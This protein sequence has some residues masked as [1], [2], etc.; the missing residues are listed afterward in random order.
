ML[1]TL[2]TRLN[3]SGTVP[4][5]GPVASI[6]ADLFISDATNNSIEIYNGLDGTVVG[7]GV[8]SGAGGLADPRAF[9]FGPDGNLYVASGGTNSILRFNGATGAF[10]DVFDTLGSSPATAIEFGP[11]GFLYVAQTDGSNSLISR[12]DAFTPGTFVDIFASVGSAPFDMEFGP[13]GNLYV[14][15]EVGSDQVIRRLG[16]GGAE[17]GGVG[18]GSVLATIPNSAAVGIAIDPAGNL[19]VGDDSNGSIKRFTSEGV[20]IDEFVA[21][22]TGG[23]SL[24]EDID[25]GADGHLYAISSSNGGEVLEFSEVDGSFIGTLVANGS[26]GLGGPSFLLFAPGF[27]QPAQDAEFV[28]IDIVWRD[29]VAVNVGTLGNDEVR[30]IAPNGSIVSG[31][32]QSVDNGTNGTPRVAT[33]RVAAPGGF[34]GAEDNGFYRVES[35]GGG[36]DDTSA[37][38]SD[39]RVLGRLLVNLEHQTPT[40]DQ[41]GS[42]VTVVGTDG[43]DLFSSFG[44]SSSIAVTVVTPQTGSIFT[45]N[46]VGGISADFITGAG[47]DVITIDFGVAIHTYKVDAGVSSTS[48]LDQL[49][50]VTGATGNTTTTLS[51]NSISGAFGSVET[52]GVEHFTLSIQGGPNHNVF[53]QSNFVGGTSTVTVTSTNGA[54]NSL[55]IFGDNT[56]VSLLVTSSEIKVE[57]QSTVELE[58]NQVLTDGVGG[59]NGLNFSQGIAQ[60]PDGRHVYVTSIIDQSVAL[61]DRDTNTGD[62]TFVAT[63]DNNSGG[64]T[65]MTSPLT[66]AVSPDGKHVYVGSQGTNALIVFDRNEVNGSLS[67]V[68]T[69]VDGTEGISGMD[70]LQHV[71]ISPDGKH[72]YVSGAASNSVAV[73]LR[74]AVSGKLSFVQAVTD[75]VNG[76]D[77]LQ[78]VVRTI[79]SNDGRNLY[80]AANGEGAVGVFARDPATGKLSFVQVLTDGGTGGNFLANVNALALDPTGSHLIAGAFVDSAI[81]VFARDA[82]TGQLTF[83]Q[84]LSEGVGGVNGITGVNDVVVS[85]DG[86]R[87]YVVGHQADSVVT[88][89]RDTGSGVLAQVDRAADGVNGFQGLD[90]VRAAIVSPDGKQVYTISFT[91]ASLVGMQT[92][93]ELAVNHSTLAAL[94]VGTGFGDD[95][96]MVLTDGLTTNVALDLGAGNDQVQINDT[97]GAD[98]VLVAGPTID[99]NGRVIAP[100]QVEIVNLGMF[101]DGADQVTI[102]LPQTAA[103]QEIQVNGSANGTDSLTINGPTAAQS[104]DLTSGGVFVGEVNAQELLFIEAEFDSVSMNAPQSVATSP[105][106]HHVYVAGADSDTIA[107]FERDT[108]SGE[109]TFLSFIQ[110]E[111]GGVT[112]L[113]GVS[114]VAVSPDGQRVYT[115]SR[116]ESKISVFDRDSGSGALTQVQIVQDGVGGVDGLQGVNQ[117]EVSPDGEFLVAT[118]RSENKIALFT[119]EANGQLTFRQGVPII[120][121]RGA[122]YSG[123]GRF[124]YVTSVENDSIVVFEQLAGGT[125]TQVQSIPNSGS[126][127]NSL[128]DPFD[129]VVSPD[130]NNVYVASDQSDSVTVFNRNQSDGTL[131]FVEAHIEGVGATTGINSASALEISPDGRKVFVAGTFSS[132]V[133]TFDRSPSGTLTFG[134][135]K[136]DEVNGVDGLGGSRFLA[137]SSDGRQLYAVGEFEDA[138]A[139][140]SLGDQVPI[141]HAGMEN[142]LVQAGDGD[143]DIFLDNSTEGGNVSVTVLGGEGNDDILVGGEGGPLILN[144]Q[145]GNDKLGSGSAG[146]LL[147]GEAGDDIFLSSAANNTMD[148]GADDDTY[149]FLDGFGEHTIIDSGG[150]DTFTFNAGI[151]TTTPLV[152][153]IDA[154]SLTI[155]SN[156]STITA[157]NVIEKIVGGTDDDQFFFVDQAVLAGGAGIIDGGPGT[158]DFL[159]Y[160]A[161]T[162]AV[163]VDLIGGIATGLS[164]VVNVEN[165]VGAGATPQL[166]GPTPYLSFADSPFTGT[167]FQYFHLED[168]TDGLLNTPGVTAN[169][170]TVFTTANFFTDSVDGD[171]G[172]VD[173]SGSREGSF[174]V[175]AGAVTLVFT[176]DEGVL[177]SLPTHAGLVWTDGL[178]NPTR[179]RAF[180]ISNNLLVDSGDLNLPNSGMVQDVTSEDVFFGVTFAGGIKRIEISETNSIEIDHLQYGLEQI[181]DT[182]VVTN[183]ND[184]GAGSLRDAITAANSASNRARIAFN[185]PDTD[186]NFIDVDSGLSGGDAGAD[187]F[188]IPLLSP[189]PALN[190]PLGIIID[191]ETQDAFTPTFNSAF[192]PSIIL[193]GT[194]AGGNEGGHGLVLSG[195]SNEIIGLTIGGFDAS[196]IVIG[197]S[198]DNNLIVASHIGVNASGTAAFANDI[199]ITV[200]G[201]NNQIGLPGGAFSNTII[202]GNNL[203]GIAISGVTATG[204]RVQNVQIGINDLVGPIDLGNVSAGIRIDNAPGNTIGGA[205]ADE[206]NVISFNGG[207][208]VA[209]QGTFSTGNI[210]RGNLIGTT[211]DGS[212]AAP[213]FV[214]VS[215][216]LGANGNQIGGTLLGEGNAIAFNTAQ[217]VRLAD[218]GTD[219]N[220]IRGVNSIFQNGALGIDIDGDGVTNND[221]GDTDNGPNQQTN[222]PVISVVNRLTGTSE[223]HVEGTIS[224]QPNTQFAIDFYADTSP[225]PSGHGEGELFLGT[226]LVTADGS[227]NAFF[228]LDLPVLAP[229]GSLV[230]ATATDDSDNTSEFS[231]A[232]AATGASTFIVTNT[233]DSGPG[234]LRQAIIDANAASGSAL[235][236]FNIP[237]TDPNFI[238]VDS[239]V[240]G[241]DPDEDAFR[242]SL[243]SALPA[244]INPLGTIIDGESQESFNAP[245]FDSNLGPAIIIDGASVGVGD[246]LALTSSNN[247]V[248]GLA[249][250]NFSGGNGIFVTGN[251]NLIVASHLGV[252]AAGSAAAGN[253]RGITISGSNNQIGMAGGGFAP[254]IIGG[255]DFDGM[256]FVSGGADNNRVQNV[257]IGINE[258]GGTAIDLGN[259]A[260]AAGI[261]ID[262]GT[263]NLIGGGGPGEGNVIAFNSEG[264]V[265][266]DESGTVVKGNLIGTDLSGNN[267]A[268]NASNG[269]SI[270][271]GANLSQIGGTAAGEGNRI[272]FNGGAGVVV[273]DVSG[274]GNAIRGNEIFENGGLGIDLNGDGVT[275]NDAGDADNG[276]NQQTNFPVIT[277]VE[278]GATTRVEGSLSSLALTTFFID[279]FLNDSP[280]PSGNGEGQTFIG[281]FPLTT[282]ASGAATFNETLAVSS[283]P[284]QFITLTATDTAGNTSEFSQAVAA[285]GAT[286]FIVTNTNDSGAGSLRQAILDANAASGAATIEFN[287]PNTDPNFIDSDVAI[288]GGDAAADVYRITLS[289]TLPSLTNPD[290]ITIGGESQSVFGGD[291]NALG[292]E[293]VLNGAVAVADGLVLSSDGNQVSGL[294]LENFTVDFLR[295]VGGNNNAIFGNYIG[296]DA[297]G[298]LGRAGV[299]FDATTGV[300]ISGNSNILDGNIISALRVGIAIAGTSSDNQIFGNFIGT[301][302][303][304]N[305]DLG[306][307]TNG[308]VVGG[309]TNNTIGQPGNG[310]VI[311]GNDNN[312]ISINGGSTT[313][314]VVQANIIGLSADLTT[315]LG[316]NGI[317]IALSDASLTR[318]GGSIPSEGNFIAHNG[319]NGVQVGLGTGNTIRNNQIFNNT[320]L[321]IDLID[322]SIFGVNPNDVGD[323]DTGS[324]NLQNFPVIT[325]VESG[326]VRIVGT[327]N[328]TPN[329]TFDIDF[330][331]NQ[332]ADAS[333]FG[334]GAIVID[335]TQVTTDGT[336]NASFDVSF[337]AG[338]VPGE[339]ITATATNTTTGDTS[340]FSQAVAAAAATTFI[341]TNTNNSG[342]GSLRQAITDANAASGAARI[343][344]NIPNTDPNFI[345]TDGAI[346]GGDAGLDAFRITVTTALPNLTNPDG[347]SI[348]GGTQLDFG[349]DTNALGPEIILS[350]GGTVNEGI[351]LASSGNEV[352]E[353]VFEN[354]TS[355]YIRI[356]NQ[357][358]NIIAGN[359]IGTD[360]SGTLDRGGASSTGVSVFGSNNTVGGAGVADRNIISGLNRGVQIGGTGS[361]NQ[362]LGN[363]IGTDRTGNFD[364]G[365][366]LEGVLVN[367]GTNAIIGAPGAGNVI[368]GNGGFGILLLNTGTN[369]TMIQ[370]NTIGADVTGANALANNSDGINVGDCDNTIIGGSDATLGNTI[371]FNG[372]NGVNVSNGNASG[373]TIRSNQIFSNSARGIDLGSNGVTINDAGDADSGANGF[374]NFP[375]ISLVEAGAVRIVG[376]LNSTPNS[377]FEVDFYSNTS[378]DPSGFGEG[379]IVIGSHQVT[380]DGSGNASFD[381]N[382]AAGIAAGNFVTA[383]ATNVTTG[384]T[385]EFSQAVVATLPGLVY[386]GPAPY[387][388][389]SDSP[390]SGLPFSSFFLENFEDG[391]LNTPG[392]SANIGSVFNSGAF[393]DGVDGDDGAV[394]GTSLTGRSFGVSSGGVTIDFSFNSAALGGFPTHAGLVWTDGQ[395]SPV[396]FEAFDA[397]GN[398]LGVSGPFTL[399]ISGVQGNTAE[400]RFFGVEFAGGISKIRI[401]DLGGAGLEVDHVQYGIAGAANTFV[402]TNTDDSGAGSLR[403]A[404]IAANAASGSS[405][406]TFSIPTSDPNFIDTDSA[407][408]G[409]DAAA[410]VWVINLLSALP[411][412][413]ANDIF[414]NGVTQEAFGGDT[415]ALGP[416][417]V[418]DGLLAGAD[419]AGLTILS[420]NNR[421]VGLNIQ[422][423]DGDAIII[424]DSDNNELGDNYIGT[425][426]T[427]TLARPNRVGVTVQSFTSAVN[428]RV[429]LSGQGNLISGNT[430]FGVRLA[431]SGAGGNFIT[432]NF[433]GTDR[434]GAAALGNAGA[435]VEIILGAHDN[436][437][438]SGQFN[439]RNVISGNAAAGVLIL[440]PGT[441]GNIVEGNFIGVNAAG[442]AAL[443]NGAS[444]VEIFGTDGNIIGQGGVGPGNV[445]SGNLGHGI[446]LD[447]ADNNSID[448]NNIGT[449]NNGVAG[450]GNALSGVSLNNGSDNNRIG[451]N[452]PQGGNVIAGNGQDGIAIFGSNN[453][454]V[455]HN[456]IGLLEGGLADGNGGD[457]VRIFGT[458]Q[459]NVIG[460]PAI[461]FADAAG[462][463]SNVS[464]P[465]SGEAG[466]QWLF[467]SAATLGGAITT[468]TSAFVTESVNG[469]SRAG[470][471]FTSGPFVGRNATGVTQTPAT[472]SVGAGQFVMAPGAT[473]DAVA[474]LT[475]PDEDIYQIRG[476]FKNGN[477]TG[478]PTVDVHILVN[479]VSVFDGFLN[480]SGFGSEVQSPTLLIDLESGDTVT[481]VVGDGNNGSTSDAVIVD[482]KVSRASG[483]LL[484]GNLGSGVA[485]SGA[486][487]SNNKVQGNLIGVDESGTLSRGNQGAAGVLIDT[488]ATNNLIGGDDLDGFGVG[489]IISGNSGAGVRMAN[490]QTSGNRVEGNIIGATMFGNTGLPNDGGGVVITSFATGN[491]VGGGSPGAGNL[492]SGNAL[493]GVEISISAAN[494]R[495]QGNRIG[496]DFQGLAALGN[497]ERG[498]FINNADGNFVGT[499]GDGSGDAT[500]GNI[501]SGNGFEGVG[502]SG[503]SATGN[504]IAGNF[505]GTNKSGA[506]AIGNS[507]RGVAIFAGA[508]NNRVGTDGNGVSD[509]NERN[510]ISGNAFEGVIIDQ[511][512]TDN[513]IIAGNFIGTDVTGLIDLG[514]LGSGVFIDLAG[515]TVIG[516]ALAS[517]RNVISGNQVHGIHVSDANATIILGNL[518]GTNLSG[519]A[520]LG[521][522]IN[523]VFVDGGAT[524]T[525]IGDG[526]VGGRNIISGNTVRGVQIDGS[527]TDIS[528]IRGNFIGTNITGTAALGN[529][530]N[531]VLLSSGATNIFVG[532]SSAG[533]GN[534]ISGNALVGVQI[535]GAS[536]ISIEGN[537]IGL[538]AAGTAALGNGESGVLI[539]QG[540]FDNAV[541]NGAASGRNIISG[542]ALVGVQIADV[543]TTNNVVDGNFIGTNAAGTADLGNGQV[544][545][546][547]NFGAT[548]NRI[549]ELDGNVI[550]G[551][552]LIGIQISDGGTGGNTVKA[553]IIGLNASGDADITDA[554]IGIDIGNGASNNTIGGPNAGD[555]NVISGHAFH[556]VRVIGATSGG[557]VIEGN[558]IGTDINGTAD[559][560][561]LFDGVQ[562]QNGPNNVVRGNL[563]SGNNGDGVDLGPGTGSVVQGNLIGTDITGNLDLGNGEAGVRLVGSIGAAIGGANAVDRNIISGNNIAGVMIQDNAT[564]NSVRGNFIGTNQAGTGALGNTFD[565]VQIFNGANGNTIGGLSVGEGNVISGN[566]QD[567]VEINGAGADGNIVQGNIIGLNALGTVALGNGQDGIRLT[568]VDTNN[569]SR[570]TISANGRD[571][572]LIDGGSTG[573]VLSGNFIGTD[574]SAAL[575]RGN[576]R[577]GVRIENSPTNT[578]GGNTAGNPGTGNGNVISGNGNAGI[579]IKGAT[580]TG[581][582]I[583]GNVIGANVTGTVAIP[584]AADGIYIAGASGNSIGGPGNGNLI[585]GN[586]GNGINIGGAASTNNVVQ[587][588]LIGTNLAGNAA[589]GNSTNG[590]FV[591]DDGARA[592]D[593]VSGYASGNFIGG[594]S[595]SSRNIL[596]GNGTFGYTTNSAGLAGTGN[597]IHGNFIGTDASGT[598]DVPNGLGGVLL[599]GQNNRL[600][601]ANP[602]EG[603]LI[604]GNDGPGV[605]LATTAANGNQIFGNLIGTALNGVDALPNIGEGVL[606]HAIGTAAINNAVGG[607]LA[608]QGNTIAFNQGP[609]VG[610][611]G[612]ATRIA[613]RGNSIFSNMGLG[614]DLELNGVTNNDLDDPDAGSNN[615]QNFPTLAAAI[616]GSTIV[617]GS[618][619]A[620]PSTVHQ[621]DFYSNNSSESGLRQGRVFIGSA[622]VTTN[623]GGDADFIVT[624]PVTTAAGDFITVTATDAN[625][626]T[627]EFSADVAVSQDTTAPTATLTTAPAVTIAGGTTYTFT[628]TYADEAALLN[629]TIGANDV[630]VHGP[631]SFG[632]VATLVS[633]STTANAASIVATYRITAPGGTFNSAD[634]GTYDI[635]AFPGAVTDLA[636]N[637]TV[638]GTLGQFTVAIGI[639]TGNASTPNVSAGGETTYR[640]TVTYADPDG[641]DPATFDGGDVIVNGPLGFTTGVTFIGADRLTRGTPRTATYEFTAPGGFL[642]AADNGGYQVVIQPNQ[643][644]D[645]R[646]AFVP[647]STAGNFTIN[648]DSSKPLVSQINIAS[649]RNQIAALTFSV[650]YADDVSINI[651]TLDDLDIRIAGP[652]GFNRRATLIGVSGS[653]GSVVASYAISPASGPFTHLNNGSYQVF[654]ESN[655]VADDSGNVAVGKLL[656]NFRVKISSRTPT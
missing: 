146:D 357:D 91:D 542:N 401:R 355:N 650:T 361:G 426:A 6:L 451:E 447:N 645:G 423:F 587:G 310:N 480:L 3:F 164:S 107:I 45:K 367:G 76:A 302:R 638:G 131:T 174:G 320:Q 167:P 181:V 110:D 18:L 215:L 77:G 42:Q 457:G 59:V 470:G 541:G 217:G 231:L 232:V 646:G 252:N 580:A 104:Y 589:L 500:E 125:L 13:D 538:N 137:M 629:S 143:D 563:I 268:G 134:E 496:T 195:A 190:N 266:N 317:G 23:L 497:D 44:N 234:S 239:A 176:F 157:D 84:A 529:G 78:D 64:I 452:V 409:G 261:R 21:G 382:L 634:N 328:S 540:A 555:R 153:T 369:G 590:I 373:V 314:T 158:G 436:F 118:G 172:A 635:I 588:N 503:S 648:I 163:S 371:A 614:I 439:D 534:V 289:S 396:S 102:N 51:N 230:S 444:G 461:D 462:D 612:N 235:I 491:F 637:G 222:F 308:V 293:I 65:N 553:N 75:G 295:I 193:D 100:V 613:I 533:Q 374:Q 594:A 556:G 492:I 419:T 343:E 68:A 625:G 360:A 115:A 300:R 177:G 370:S 655:Q 224:G 182:F 50:V 475:V 584:N 272:A 216:F 138:V 627:S 109:L 60:S 488:E 575:D 386:L 345:N 552:N 283:S 333:G 422:R 477:A 24:P 304:G 95:L 47:A 363:F 593:P 521:N 281:S 532:G 113:D 531:G 430:G 473:G 433:I 390:F 276:P 80:T 416:E 260:G 415:N 178:S 291:T 483:N 509:V 168:F 445:I 89:S 486:G 250:T 631:N 458:S 129:V 316:N 598:T 16:P 561:N 147:I 618:L 303:T 528:S 8:A 2:E 391:L 49:T 287:I 384:N 472:L 52:I 171:D 282:N 550:S 274:D 490:S 53:S 622:Q 387:L 348:I 400:D 326:A 43:T 169:T 299:G 626:N 332:T 307:R 427:G 124:L 353:L 632:A 218:A 640:F 562:I 623:A 591:G 487:T 74:D 372:G 358:S 255:N 495:V 202:G 414:I 213:N 421:I 514:N 460:G 595:V 186:A 285:A 607:V 99:F 352:R 342:A 434:T 455:N 192:G 346:A 96:A 321:G 150:F 311:S 323:A 411:A 161:Y 208:G 48:D 210:V 468:F 254:T 549:G 128:D 185:I 647:S 29:D 187:A 265:I 412:I 459:G 569:I 440:D 62:L 233:S 324:N 489:N 341:V 120:G 617:T 405:E 198:S 406:I 257:R 313:G 339:F 441:T 582:S 101:G 536:A 20:F 656:T 151:P 133:V 621:L 443:G 88:F 25:F 484:S 336:G 140:F 359:Y 539:N 73:F 227:G 35:L 136:I 259:G 572:V 603:N 9:A 469:W 206:G 160:T 152:V 507:G 188:R 238:D 56:P 643:V 513:N 393:Q 301:D 644:S 570:N 162:T 379:Q 564:N 437:I 604:S 22:G 381:V 600:G 565:G 394:D 72:L 180:D 413:T 154:A 229:A 36:V 262:G 57:S 335:S 253:D 298:T 273:L 132:A 67:F 223:T 454:T 442:A 606:A 522:S 385:S 264:I 476:V 98:T 194:S 543:G 205:G 577:N 4:A 605:T 228:N 290:G 81:T 103:S 271:Q 263:G 619:N 586:I 526:T 417:I 516:G 61:F 111:N 377:T 189:L 212:A 456:R 82:G 438:G 165:V 537:I 179:F 418:I 1:E 173:G 312:G 225:D 97:N 399:T 148:G 464:N 14:T 130:G 166:L 395:G 630:E 567:G 523:G 505:I 609:G 633:K 116:F 596:S 156:G 624:L 69:H 510:I 431:G 471:S 349:G 209:I 435:G 506:A 448:G 87:V 362:I 545:V 376:T 518:I 478:N 467:G 204:N 220:A 378:A 85:P 608:G 356:F 601:G 351:V 294:V 515:N 502:I 554:Q 83:A 28:D 237:D 350:G 558:F 501:I 450:P 32:F 247:E 121:P 366:A 653:G 305:A 70:G 122:D 344:F 331:L 241:G 306:N 201:G 610:V 432:G 636:G 55:F 499:D 34:W 270:I 465:V 296:T 508:S 368:A 579:I 240:S 544:G 108:G 527:G 66:I 380:T 557:N 90:G 547:V 383:T 41:Q 170:G 112:G 40:F 551:N 347:I 498:V 420:D 530:E 340:E 548:G 410:D 251:D 642:D 207:F 226:A 592:T 651:S 318:I 602:G 337:A 493:S 149:E 184:S 309:G 365:N 267:P 517:Q 574:T 453:N 641:I 325:L 86:T 19:Y 269:I 245:N 277:L 31:Q 46:F 566:A 197:T 597:S 520:A 79:V 319:G 10:I 139:V 221:V 15:G 481:F 463:F 71:S 155:V 535:A 403:D 388:Q 576:A 429:G 649:I 479:G 494:N 26:G 338:V 571:G 106:G 573:N 615:R 425:D 375:V 334:E 288:A 242:I 652:G 38:G 585:S 7:D 144:G 93:F 54:D 135:A 114:H 327:L 599:Q 244:V 27:D 249:I 37:N 407:I 256:R 92:R 424:L 211:L 5:G 525:T 559:R 297:S 126:V 141:L 583:L 330:Y 159:D 639:P 196:G 511:T 12:Y 428:N 191:G 236:E 364:L 127:N 58:F 329:T 485:I 512:G 404:I 214:G 519:T 94:Q 203:D 578:I 17:R 322:V 474:R 581:I 275:S 258:I 398:S 243:L 354:F 504:V 30:I 524:Q 449:L 279:V 280:D 446:L 620:R 286:T 466:L 142:L 654:L 183:T 119:V 145:G 292:P 63:F 315:P 560:G 546:L 175:V 611:A 568:N 482:A 246:G 284:G 389:A 117:I 628:V 248:I 33:Y 11:D 392:L 39:N 219:N 105:D 199:G 397:S 200:Q 616:Q 278:S 402:V 408:A 123:D